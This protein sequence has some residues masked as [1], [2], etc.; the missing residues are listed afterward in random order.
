MRTVNKVAYPFGKP[1]G[2]IGRTTGMRRAAARPRTRLPPLQN[3]R[4]ISPD[5]RR[6][7]LQ[8]DGNACLICGA[9][10]DLELHH[11]VPVANGGATSAN[12]LRTLCARCHRG[13]QGQHTTREVR[14]VPTVTARSIT[15]QPNLP[16]PAPTAVGSGIKGLAA[17][18]VIFIVF[19]F[20]IM[21][22]CMLFLL[23]PSHSMVLLL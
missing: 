11:V 2:G 13:P 7:V 6:A 22:G 12:N 5:L 9:R 14:T 20:I 8:R 15:A 19:L 23:A 18:A 3:E 10:T 4:I 21:A 1:R 16:S 17:I